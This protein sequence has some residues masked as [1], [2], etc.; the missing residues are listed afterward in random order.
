M[1]GR[2][3]SRFLEEILFPGRCL[4]CG[5]WLLPVGDGAVPLCNGCRDSL[6][7]LGGSRCRR[8]GIELVS[9]KEICVRCRTTEYSFDSNLSLFSYSGA[10]K[11][12]LASFKFEGRKRL[13]SFFAERVAMV[14][15]ALDPAG[16]VVIPAPPR[17]GRRSPD[18]VELVARMLE[19]IHGIT[20]LHLLSRAGHVQ[21]K[22]LD[23]EQ[24]RA[25]LKGNISMARR[26]M[27]GILPRSVVLLDDVFTT[28]ATLDAC[29]RVL[30]LA[31]CMEV[32]A[33]TLAM[34]E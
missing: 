11:R 25:N 15:A 9:E 1:L 18:A 22:T 6:R 13:A 17:P 19:K 24:R 2:Q 16:S 28:G 26:K 32:T 10:A 34:E 20:V 14:L 21:Q 8:C 33:V 31:G 5:E 23:Y 29:A 4:Q 30:R 12:L 7:T 3:A 27:D